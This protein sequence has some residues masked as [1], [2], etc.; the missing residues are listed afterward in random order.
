V[1]ACGGRGL[2]QTKHGGEFTTRILP[3]ASTIWAGEELFDLDC[4]AKSGAMGAV[5]C[6]IVARNGV[7]GAVKTASRD[8]DKKNVPMPTAQWDTAPTGQC[9]SDPVWIVEIVRFD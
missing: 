6:G 2:C 3:I 7:N 5:N 8:A 1:V 4:C 9:G